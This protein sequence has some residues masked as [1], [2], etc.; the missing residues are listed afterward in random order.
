MSHSKVTIILFFAILLLCR[1]SC[2][3]KF[4]FAKKCRGSISF[5][6]YNSR[7]R[8]KSEVR[9]A[10]DT[11]TGNCDCEPEVSMDNE[12]MIKLLDYYI[13]EHGLTV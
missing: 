5:A 2:K 3:T 11:R 9:I 4:W 10:K 6:I 7:D 13:S 12:F 1:V 8:E